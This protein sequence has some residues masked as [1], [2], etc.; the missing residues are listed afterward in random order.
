MMVACSGKVGPPPL[1]ISA[2]HPTFRPP[3]PVSGHQSPSQTPWVKIVHHSQSQTLVINKEQASPPPQ[4]HT[5]HTPH[6]LLL[7]GPLAS[8]SLWRVCGEQ[9]AYQQRE[10]LGGQGINALRVPCNC[11]WPLTCPC[12]RGEG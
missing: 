5:L 8:H 1:I 10:P 3:C 9:C 6:P 2:P 7:F 4:P 12:C 11:M